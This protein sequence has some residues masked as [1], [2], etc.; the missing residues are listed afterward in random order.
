GRVESG[1]VDED[2]VGVADGLDVRDAVTG[3]LGTRVDDR[4]LLT[5]QAVQERRLP[6]VGAPD[7]RHEPGTVGYC[8]GGHC[9]GVHE[10][11][12]FR[13]W[14]ETGAARLRHARFTR[15]SVAPGSPNSMAPVSSVERLAR[16]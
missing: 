13:G 15:G 8:G 14:P 9:S 10:H 2:A 3:G 1:C 12:L 7:E 4:E 16:P 6:G 5:Y 11:A